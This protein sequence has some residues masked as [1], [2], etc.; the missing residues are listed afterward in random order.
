ML[1]E[2]RGVVGDA[3]AKGIGRS[4]RANLHERK[5]ASARL[6]HPERS[7]TCDAQSKDRRL[8]CYLKRKLSHLENF[9]TVLFIH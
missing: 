3:A 6:A 9:H 4:D 7:V 5:R 2:K 1:D 8:C